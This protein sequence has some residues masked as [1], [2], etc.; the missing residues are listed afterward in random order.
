VREAVSP[1]A[2]VALV[3]CAALPELTPDDRLLRAALEAQGASVEACLWD[4]RVAWDAFDSVVLRSCWDYHLRLPEFLGFIARMEAERVPLWNPPS[5]VRGNVHKSYLGD[6]ERAGVRVA[7]TAFLEK[8]SEA[9]LAETLEER[10]WRDAVVKPAV[11][12][13]AYG[14]FRAFLP[15]SPAAEAEFQRLLGAGD[16]LVQP[17]VREVVESGEWSFV[18]LGGAFSHAVL[19]QAA[20]DEFRVQGEFGGRSEPRTPPAPILRQVGRIVER[21]PEP[22]L[23]ARI[24]AIDRGGDLV[25]MEIELIEPELFLRWGEGAAARLARSILG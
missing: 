23:Y 22:W 25:L 9:G 10:G 14:T 7:E 5:L 11:S 24:D 20:S 15:T 6:W 19:K 2:K 1:K 4:G 12:A 18:C 8:G 21:I 17:F 3:T 13:S 16:V